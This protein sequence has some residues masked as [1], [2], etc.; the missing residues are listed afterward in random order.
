MMRLNL[1]K[2]V[3]RSRK[4]KETEAKMRREHT[5]IR[6]G[7]HSWRGVAWGIRR[8]NPGKL[9][10]V[11]GRGHCGNGAVDR[12]VMPL[13]LQSDNLVRLAVPVSFSGG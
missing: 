13:F 10:G 8:P 4:Q 12:C 3:S 1:G 7:D 11:H 6:P 9:G 2:S 5:I